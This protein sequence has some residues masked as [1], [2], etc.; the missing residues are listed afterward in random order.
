MSVTV[1]VVPKGDRPS[2]KFHNIHEVTII[3]NE[4]HGTGPVGNLHLLSRGRKRLIV[5]G[6]NIVAVEL[7]G[8]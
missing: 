3:D 1:K 4:S 2:E 8:A 5:G 6:P 7:E